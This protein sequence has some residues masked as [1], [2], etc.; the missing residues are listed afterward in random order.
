MSERIKKAKVAYSILAGMGCTFELGGILRIYPPEGYVF[1][2][3][4]QSSYLRFNG[5]WNSVPMWLFLYGQTKREVLCA[6]PER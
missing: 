2:D 6:T 1:R 4:V 3:S 5:G